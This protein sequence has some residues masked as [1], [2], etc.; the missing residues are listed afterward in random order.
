M[1]LIGAFVPVAL[2]LYASSQP[3]KITK[4]CNALVAIESGA[5]LITKASNCVNLTLVSQQPD[6]VFGYSLQHFQDL[7]GD[8]FSDLLIGSP[9]TSSV[10]SGGNLMVVSPETGG[11]IWQTGGP[12]GMRSGYHAIVVDDQDLDGVPDILVA[13]YD[14]GL[15]PYTWLV[16]G[17]S[18]HTLTLIRENIFSV[19]DAADSGKQIYI[20]TDI[21]GSKLVDA[22][23][24][25]G[26]IDIYNANGNTADLNKDGI[27][28]VLDLQ[29]MLDDFIQEKQIV[30]NNIL[31]SPVPPD[32]VAIILHP[33]GTDPRC[34]HVLL[35][36]LSVT[37][38]GAVA[39]A[40]ISTVCTPQA[41]ALALM[42]AMEA[43][44]MTI[45]AIIAM[46]AMMGF[47]VEV[48]AQVTGLAIPAVRI[49]IANVAGE[50]ARCLKIYATYKA[51]C[52]SALSCKGTANRAL[53][54]QYRSRYLLNALCAILRSKH[55]TDCIPPF[56]RHLWDVDGGHGNAIDNRW[57]AAAK[58][59]LLFQTAGCT[60]GLP[61]TGPR[62]V[63]AGGRTVSS[64][65]Y[66]VATTCTDGSIHYSTTS[67]ST[68][69]SS[70]IGHFSDSPIQPIDWNFI[71]DE[72][73]R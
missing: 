17:Q 44:G 32:S 48:I 20:P 33:Q 47:S 41:A 54:D 23:D 35:A 13:C 59:S 21:D 67:C 36:A 55:A 1:G 71:N 62:P 5:I 65:E 19:L 11:V 52:L 10:T 46:L 15:V 28:D 70:G 6:S 50:T 45:A 63:L 4:P 37:A 73:H 12:L 30:Q 29:I 64:I 2:P 40:A 25:F 31:I 58:C 72:I 56:L 43:R 22:N 61:D 16:S 66:D 18:G 7:D 3:Y 69:E 57:T 53:C 38:A 8:D 9:P 14:S 68:C 60:G 27:V 42:L 24:F 49:V 34:H 26:F 39:Q 51:V